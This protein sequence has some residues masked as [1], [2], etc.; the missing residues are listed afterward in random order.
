MMKNPEVTGKL[1]VLPFF[2][3]ANMTCLQ[4]QSISVKRNQFERRKNMK[5]TLRVQ[6]GEFDGL[7]DVYLHELSLI[8]KIFAK[9]FFFCRILF[10]LRMNDYEYKIGLRKAAKGRR[11]K[12][13][14][15]YL[16]WKKWSVAN[17]LNSCC[18]I[19][20]FIAFILSLNCILTAH[21]LFYIFFLSINGE[22][23]HLNF[24][25]EKTFC[26]AKLVMWKVLCCI[27]E[28]KKCQN[29]FIH[30]LILSFSV[31]KFPIEMIYDQF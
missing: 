28:R 7:T 11:D 2:S 3:N 1:Y 26:C 12:L 25:Q 9:F 21:L 6:G 22:I 15:I 19:A 18:T 14:D 10:P 24:I 17:S 5:I 23:C 20:R 13:K 16:G 31:N 27:K 30:F 4:L 8:Q 29:E